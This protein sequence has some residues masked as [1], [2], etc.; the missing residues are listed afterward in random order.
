MGTGVV[1][2]AR[3]ARACAEAIL[4]Q[5]RTCLQPPNTPP[6]TRRPLPDGVESCTSFGLEGLFQDYLDI[7]FVVDGHL[8]PAV[9]PGP[10]RQVFDEMMN[11]LVASP[12]ISWV[13][14]DPLNPNSPHTLPME[15][16][17]PVAAQCI[18]LFL[19]GLVAYAQLLHC[20]SVAHQISLSL[21]VAS[22][23]SRQELGQ[24]KPEHLWA[25][26]PRVAPDAD[27]LWELKPQDQIPTD[28]L[29]KFAA[30]FCG[31]MNVQVRPIPFCICTYTLMIF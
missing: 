5:L 19:A 2:R 13:K 24:M 31:R 9:G 1:V 15:P 10:K 26:D 27:L 6:S 20:S 11:I 18:D 25:L 17:T 8:Q 12:A 3:D 21:L 14:S 30:W 23:V 16:S 22:S 7:K 28:P 29:G 4:A